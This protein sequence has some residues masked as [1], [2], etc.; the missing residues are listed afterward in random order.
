VIRCFD[1]FCYQTAIKRFFS[2]CE[3]GFLELGRRFF[4]CLR[5]KMTGDI[6]GDLNAGVAQ[7]LADVLRT[8]PLRDQHGREEMT[9][10]PLAA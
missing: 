10:M 9:I 5:K 8:F 6:E 3:H 4:S 2:A 1:R 7:L